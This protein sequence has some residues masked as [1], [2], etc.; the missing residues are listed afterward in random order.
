LKKGERAFIIDNKTIYV[1]ILSRHRQIYILQT[2]YNI[3]NRKYSAKNIIPVS[4]AL[5][6]TI[7]IP[8]NP[9]KIFLK[10][11]ARKESRAK[12]LKISY[13]YKKF[14]CSKRYTC[15]KAG[16]QYTFFCYSLNTLYRN[17]A[18]GPDFNIY[19]IINIDQNNTE[20]RDNAKKG[21]SKG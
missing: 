9:T 7:E 4:T 8:D 3:I 17:E 21:A 5:A 2:Q 1:R 11:V 6:K 12:V 14:L 20:A 15:R 19:T 10:G 16:K 18:R 13:R